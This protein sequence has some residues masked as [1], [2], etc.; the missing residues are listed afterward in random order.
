MSTHSCHHS[1]GLG[2]G[3]G[4]NFFSHHAGRFGFHTSAAGSKPQRTKRDDALRARQAGRGK[5]DLIEAGLNE[6][7]DG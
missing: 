5:R 6:A 7:A 3:G 4:S 1:N 2:L